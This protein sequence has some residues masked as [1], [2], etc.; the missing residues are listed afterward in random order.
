LIWAAVLRFDAPM[1]Q[2]KQAAVEFALRWQS[3]EATHSERLYFERVNFWRDFCP[4]TLGEQLAVLPTGG[5]ASQSFAAGELVPAYNPADAHRVS[6]EQ[7]R[8]KLRS[9]MT[10]TPR[11]GASIHAAWSA[12]CRT[13]SPANFARCGIWARRMAWRAWI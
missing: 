10:I 5:A 6:P 13:C 11:A 4:G 1:Q 3:A 8:I 7:V 9:G 12:G 2:T